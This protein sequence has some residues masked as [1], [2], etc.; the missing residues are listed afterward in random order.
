MQCLLLFILSPLSADCPP[1]YPSNVWSGANVTHIVAPP[2]ARVIFAPDG[3]AGPRLNGLLD[4]PVFPEQ[5]LRR[6]LEHF[7]KVF[8]S[9]SAVLAAFDLCT[10]GKCSGPLDVALRLD[11]GGGGEGLPVRIKLEQLPLDF[12]RGAV[13][14]EMLARTD[15]NLPGGHGNPVPRDWGRQV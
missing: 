9:R 13:E 8:A 3:K 12:V 2:D 11:G 5:M 15:L 1:V 7:G 4:V 10:R 6:V 14:N